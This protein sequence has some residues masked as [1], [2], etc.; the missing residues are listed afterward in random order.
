M[1]TSEFG[2]PALRALNDLHEVVAV[3]TRP[4]SMRG[5]GL[6]REPAPIAV[7][8]A[9]L[10]LPVLAPEK[11]TNPEFLKRLRAFEADLFF[12]AAFRILPHEV[13]SMPSKGTVNL[14]GSLLPDY[15]GAAPIQWAVI[16]GDA[17]TGIT[18]FYIQEN[19]DT[20]DVIFSEHI[21]IGLDE[22]AGELSLRMSE[23]G[24]NLAI[25][26]VDAISAGTAPR[27]RQPACGGRP[28]PKLH[29]RDGHIDWRRDARSIYNQVRGMNP[30][31]GAFTMWTRGP[32]KIR[33]VRIEDEFS[34]GTPGMTAKASPKEGLSVYCGKGALRILELQPP[35]KQ[36]MDGASFVRGYR[37]E[38]GTSFS[39]IEEP[40][41]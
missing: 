37:V 27:I 33:R 29:K 17:E 20:G 35:G 30:E 5:R 9:R 6:H 23:A 14:H 28:A 15:R 10:G 19:V 25:K 21:I 31:P 7:A 11:L 1:G 41:P 18:T 32:L 12:V 16:N 39:G 3:V 2:A 26:T 13:F 40:A 24:A 8:G 34:A 38:A 4:D 22:T 36:P